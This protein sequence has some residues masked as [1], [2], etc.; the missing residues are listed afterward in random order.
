MQNR[1]IFI[2]NPAARTDK[3]VI[4]AI[5]VIYVLLEFFVPWDLL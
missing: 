3:I 1:Y 2:K 4:A 5:I